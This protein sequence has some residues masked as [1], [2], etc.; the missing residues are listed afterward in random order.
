[1]KRNR[2]YGILGLGCLAGYL[3]LFISIVNLG[4]A[5]YFTPCIFK[6]ET[7]FACP[8]CGSTRALMEL[9]RGDVIASIMVNPLGLLLGAVL[10]VTPFWIIFD[11]ITRRQTLFNFYSKAEETIRI[12]WVAAF[13]IILIIVNWIWN[14]KKNL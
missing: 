6:L 12:K 2:L 5:E 13:L 9:M 8:S 1:M 10:L 7:G 11:L 4:D 14:I 3:W